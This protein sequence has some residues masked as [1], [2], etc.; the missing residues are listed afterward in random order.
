MKVVLE[1]ETMHPDGEITKGKEIAMMDVDQEH[2]AVKVMYVEAIGGE[3]KKTRSTL[4]IRPNS[5]R[6][7]KQGEIASDLMYEEGC[8]HHTRY[9]TPYGSIPMTLNTKT[10][11]H[12]S[13]GVDYQKGQV[14]KRFEI[15][16]QL[17]Y[18]F[19]M[20]DGNPMEMQMQLR[21]AAMQ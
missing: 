12:S 13:K 1:F 19:D 17:L 14:E 10:F 2:E 21:V 20:G 5:L 8:K 6:V 11:S 16:L 15:V 7:Q 4:W 3:E 9:H 18:S